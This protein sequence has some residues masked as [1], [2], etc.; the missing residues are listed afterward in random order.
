MAQ[1][2]VAQGLLFRVALNQTAALRTQSH[3]GESSSGRFLSL[4]LSSFLPLHPSVFP[5][6]FNAPPRHLSA[7]PALPL[8]IFPAVV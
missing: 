6:P 3:A 7:A 4:S 2:W 8:S 5:S 1:R